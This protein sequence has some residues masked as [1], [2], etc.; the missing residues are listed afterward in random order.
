MTYYFWLGRDAG[1]PLCDGDLPDMKCV[2]A[3]GFI[4]CYFS[5]QAQPI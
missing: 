5:G 3:D 1:E 2:E 4:T